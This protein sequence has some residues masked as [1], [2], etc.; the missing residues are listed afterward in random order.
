MARMVTALDEIAQVGPGHCRHDTPVPGML[1]GTL[2]PY[3][4]Y[5]DSVCPPLRQAKAKR[6]KKMLSLTTSLSSLEASS[7]SKRSSHN[8][9]PT[10]R[11]HA[12][13]APMVPP[14]KL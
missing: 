8:N 6:E 11:S 10:L 13:R 2:H 9:G 12:A 5:A 4:R 7:I 14:L 1:P 3:A